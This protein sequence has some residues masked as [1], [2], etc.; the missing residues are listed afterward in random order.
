MYSIM[1]SW[2]G[3]LIFSPSMS[4]ACLDAVPPSDLSPSPSAF[5]PGRTNCT[6]IPAS[7]SPSFLAR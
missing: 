3:N 6:C 5:P 2:Y 4:L 1:L 7:K